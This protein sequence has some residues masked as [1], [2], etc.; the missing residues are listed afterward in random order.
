MITALD[1]DQNRY[2]FAEL[3]FRRYVYMRENQPYI[4]FGND[5]S[6]YNR[7]VISFCVSTPSKNSTGRNYIGLEPL[8][9]VHERKK[10]EL[11]R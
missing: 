6:G 9:E 10:R 3:K 2:N 11:L 5:E 4:Y 8:H 1:I 7:R